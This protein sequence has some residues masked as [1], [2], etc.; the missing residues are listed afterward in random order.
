MSAAE[1]Y[2]AHV[3]GQ[4]DPIQWEALTPREQ[5]G[6]KYAAG[7]VEKVQANHPLPT[8]VGVIATVTGVVRTVEAL[9]PPGHLRITLD[10]APA[11]TEDRDEGERPLPLHRT[12]AGYPNCSTCDGGGCLD[13]TD[14]A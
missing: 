13:C 11:P 9:F 8:R 7:L 2:A 1:L 4:A 5:A 12:E 6:W 3:R 10:A 14:P